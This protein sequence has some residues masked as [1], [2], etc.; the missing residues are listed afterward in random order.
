[1]LGRIDSVN[2]SFA[3]KHGRMKFASFCA[4]PLRGFESRLEKSFCSNRV[5][6]FAVGLLVLVECLAVDC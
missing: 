4:L 5:E 3:R 6:C 1:M 2:Q